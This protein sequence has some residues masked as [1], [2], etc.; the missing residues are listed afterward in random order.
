MDT[1]ASAIA[2]LEQLIA[3]PSVSRQEAATATILQEWF[4]VR[5]VHTKRLGNNIIVEHRSSNPDAPVLLLNS[6]HDTI[7]PR[8]G[9]DTNPYV[10]TWDGDILYGLGS[11]DAGAALVTMAS[12]F[13]YVRTMPNLQ[14]HLVFVATAEEEISGTGGMDLL[15]REYFGNAEHNMPIPSLALVGEPTGM[16]LAIAERGLIV[17]DC[18]AT[19]STGHAAR[20]E[21]INAIYKAMADIEWFRTHQ[22]DRISETLGAVQMTVTQIGAGTQHNV[23]PDACAY[24]V[25]VR[26]TDAYTNQEV[27]DIITTNVSSTIKPRSLRLQPSS[28]PTAHR[29]VQE[30]IAMG[31]TTYGS[32]TMSDQSLLPVGVPSLK[33]GPGDSARSHTPNEYIKRTEIENGIAVLIELLERYVV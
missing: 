32:P 17:I 9:W 24:V 21:G 30:G 7:I 11:N 33:I 18:I 27:L 19:G 23:V 5:N 13:M 16:Q 4:H 1:I 12:A 10:P 3:T 28:I 29:I 8:D 14:H 31:L 22:Y 20:Q 6:H 2:L 26:T 15:T 25:D